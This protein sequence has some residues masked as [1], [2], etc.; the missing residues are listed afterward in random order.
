MQIKKPRVHTRPHT[1]LL[2]CVFVLK[3]ESEIQK[4]SQ[5]SKIHSRGCAAVI[6]AAAAELR[7]GDGDDVGR[8]ERDAKSSKCRERKQRRRDT[9]GVQGGGEGNDAGEM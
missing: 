2:F 6:G 1:P 7:D 4:N 3:N 9:E 5:A 8:D